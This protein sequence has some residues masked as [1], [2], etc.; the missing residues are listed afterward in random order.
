MFAVILSATQQNRSTQF[1]IPTVQHMSPCTCNCTIF[2]ADAF[3]E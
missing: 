2:T 1:K 3:G